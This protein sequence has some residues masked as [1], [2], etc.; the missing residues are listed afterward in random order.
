MA[1]AASKK[2]LRSASRGDLFAA[3]LRPIDPSVHYI[4]T[5]AAH[6]LR[7]TSSTLRTWR[8]RKIGP[9]FRK[10]GGRVVYFGADLLKFLEN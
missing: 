5:E 1:R 6:L 7:V 4:E 9:R 2:R 10:A 8:A 3:H